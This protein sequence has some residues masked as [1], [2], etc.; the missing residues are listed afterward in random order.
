MIGDGFMQT[1]NRIYTGI[2]FVCPAVF[3][4][5]V[6]TGFVGFNGLAEYLPMTLA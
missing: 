6:N 5:V 2:C 4:Y 1:M 3:F